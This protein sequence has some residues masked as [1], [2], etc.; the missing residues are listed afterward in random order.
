MPSDYEWDEAMRN[1]DLNDAP[2]LEPL[3]EVL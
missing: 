2:A 3:V 1:F